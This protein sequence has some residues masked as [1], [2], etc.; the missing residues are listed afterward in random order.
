[1]PSSKPHPAKTRAIRFS[2]PFND[3]PVSAEPLHQLEHQVKGILPGAYTP[4]RVGPQPYPAEDGLY[5][6]AG[7]QVHP[8]FFGI[9]VEGDEVLPVPEHCFRRRSLALRTQPG[10]ISFSPLLAKGLRLRLR[11]LPQAPSHLSLQ[12]FGQLASYVQRPVVPATLV[13]GGG[14]DLVQG[15]PQ[16]QSAVTHRQQGRGASPR[17]RRSRI[18]SAQLSVLSR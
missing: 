11:H 15:C 1:M 4:G 2:P 16:A 12:P 6:V 8:V 13:F 9:V 5:G 3:P 18:T 14:E 17:S 10:H 7:S